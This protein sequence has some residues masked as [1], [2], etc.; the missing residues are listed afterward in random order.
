MKKFFLAS[1]VLIFLLPFAAWAMYK[2]MRVLAP[3]WVEGV[4]CIDSEICL[5][6]KSQ[7]KV[8]ERLYRGALRDVSRVIG[9]FKQNPRVIFCSTQTCYQSFGFKNASA[10]NVGTSGIV[11]SPRG[12]KYYYLCHE[13]IHYRQAE[14]LGIISSSFKPEW[15][16]EGMAYSL[17]GDPRKTLSNRWQTDRDRFNKWIQSVGMDNLWEEAKKI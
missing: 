16:I 11:I 4:T 1:V 2:P 10:T 3:G 9:Q 7:H 14:E 6:D 15:L 8:A 13:M 12:W 5:E 17:S